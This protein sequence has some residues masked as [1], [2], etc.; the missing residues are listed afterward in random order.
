VEFSR[1]NPQESLMLRTLLHILDNSTFGERYAGAIADDD[2]IEQAN[3]DQGKRVLDA[4]RDPLVGQ[5]RLRDA[6]RVLGFIRE[7]QPGSVVCC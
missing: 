1:G 3:I 2:V 6:G 4:Q 5:A 7:C